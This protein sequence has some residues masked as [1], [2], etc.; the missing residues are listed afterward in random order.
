MKSRD[1]QQIGLKLSPLAVEKLV[2]FLA[3]IFPLEEG[4]SCEAS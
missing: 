1:R 2:E 4:L 3:A